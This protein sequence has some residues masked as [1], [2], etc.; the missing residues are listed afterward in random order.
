VA[1]A[2][3]GPTTPCP[4]HGTRDYAAPE[5]LQGYQTDFS[6]QFSLAV[7]YHVLR[8]GCF[9][10]PPAPAGELPKAFSRPAADLT[11]L[12]TA[13]EQAALA[14]ALNPVPQDRFPNCLT[15]TQA[16]LKAL[17]YKVVTEPEK[18]ARAVKDEEPAVEPPRSS[19]RARLLAGTP[20]PNGAP[21]SRPGVPRPTA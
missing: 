10:F 4:R 13:G 11:A 16:L 6:D 18:P 17:G 7:T 5:V 3:S 19:L 14:R 9:P 1:T 8:T 12:P 2:T 21:G 15:L 20:V